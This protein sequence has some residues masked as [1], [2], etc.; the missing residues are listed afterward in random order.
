[1]I[2]NLRKLVLRAFPEF[3]GMH[4]TRVGEIVAIA[5]PLTEEEATDR[6]RPRFAVDVQLLTPDGEDDPDQPILEGLALPTFG[7]GDGRGV[8]AFPDVGTRVRVGYDYGLAT[9]PYIAAI[10]PEGR[11]LPTLK[12]GEILIQ[13]Q[14]GCAIRFDPDGN[15]SITTNG[16]LTIDAHAIEVEADLV[17]ETLGQVTRTIDGAVVE[18]LGDLD[19]TI[20]GGRG[21]QV[22]GDSK[23]VVLGAEERAILGDKSEVVTGAAEL[24]S[25]LDLSLTSGTGKVA[26]KAIAGNIEAEAAVDLSLTAVAGAVEIQATAGDVLIESI[27]GLATL[28][29]ALIAELN[30]SQVKVGSDAQELLAI[31]NDLLTNLMLL[32][33]TC[34]APG[35][36]SGVPINVASFLAEQTNLATILSP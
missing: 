20:L 13:Q 36:P 10:L 15:L 27:A 28:K 18:S 35:S 3:G 16:A 6:F 17:E 5:D 8:F 29:A 26:L 7:T 22:G 25:G 12:P 9:H 19:Q 30:G 21:V 33:V 23:E 31:V 32:T 14:D 34:T 2:K 24:V 11:F 4:L 1:M